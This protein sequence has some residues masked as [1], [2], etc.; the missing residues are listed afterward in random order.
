[1]E[2]IRTIPEARCAIAGAKLA[3]RSVGLVPT[4]GALH[5]GH[6]SL[7]RQ[8]R[9]ECAFTVVSVFVNPTQFG[10]HE[11][12]AAY[13]RTLDADAAL[14]RELGA[15]VVFAPNAQ[16]MYPRE[17]LAWVNV[18]RLGEHLCG[19]TRPGHFR[20]VCTVVLKLFNALTPDRAYFG[21]KDFQQLAILTRMAGDLN[22]PV[23]IVPCPTVRE[24]DGLA[25]S[26]RNRY[27]SDDQ[28]RQ[29]PSLYKALTHAREMVRHG[30]TDAQ[31]ILEAVR[32]IV[33]AHPDASVDYIS[34]V[35]KELLQPLARVDRPGVLAMAVRLG[36]ARL[37]DNISVDP[38]VA[39]K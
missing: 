26:S 19:A 16:E 6:A 11:D 8:C 31:A 34:L 29:A 2:L 5:E 14:C 39:M 9:R 7:I 21:E 17:Q 15:D 33:E 27:L 25:I 3:A 24:S 4:M 12:L 38:P 23:Q 1:M 35:D 13:P 28:R 20:G 30:Q 18:E 37:I 10:P 32:Q 36:P 22:V